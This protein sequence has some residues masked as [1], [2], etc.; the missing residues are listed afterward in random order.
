MAERIVLLG[1]DPDELR[2]R[3]MELLQNEG[4]EVCSLTTVAEMYA[5]LAIHGKP[6]RIIC[7]MVGLFNL[8]KAYGR[9]GYEFLM[10]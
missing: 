10:E 5:W 8:D 6:D 9:T 2:A 3:M 1:I 7:D 4:Y